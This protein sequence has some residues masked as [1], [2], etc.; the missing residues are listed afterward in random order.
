MLGCQE[1]RIS[2]VQGNLRFPPGGL[3]DLCEQFI[4]PII[5]FIW[6]FP[7]SALKC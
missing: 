3:L 2:I 6:I 4:N 5:R 1:N 7:L